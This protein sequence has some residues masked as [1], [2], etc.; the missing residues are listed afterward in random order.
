MAN[1]LN[2]YEISTVSQIIKLV[3][4]TIGKILIGTKKPQCTYTIMQTVGHVLM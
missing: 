3:Q 1:F 2:L 4:P